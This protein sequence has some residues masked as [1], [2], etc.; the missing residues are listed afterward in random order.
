MS[1]LLKNF[2]GAFSLYSII[3]LLVG[4][5]GGYLYYYFIGC[6]SG[7]CS[8]TSNPYLSVAWGLILGWLIGGLFNKKPTSDKIENNL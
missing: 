6:Q 5:A 8:I 2:R 3:G 1:K 7:S 4:A